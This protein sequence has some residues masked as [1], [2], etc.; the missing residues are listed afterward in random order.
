[1][2]VSEEHLLPSSIKAILTLKV[3]YLLD[4]FVGI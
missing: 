2:G 3:K 1:M 4:P